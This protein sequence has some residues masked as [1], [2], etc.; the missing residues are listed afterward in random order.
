MPG[1]GWHAASIRPERMKALR[2]VFRRYY[3]P[4]DRNDN[5]FGEDKLREALTSCA[6]MSAVE[7]RDEVVSRV[8]E[9]SSALSTYASTNLIRSK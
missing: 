5:E 4:L 3:N 1:G 6:Y 7:V 9:W 2:R 8:R